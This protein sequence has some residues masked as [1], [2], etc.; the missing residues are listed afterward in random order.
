MS[1]TKTP[2]KTPDGKDAPKHAPRPEKTVN[3]P[4]QTVIDGKTLTYVA[5]AGTLNLRDP[6]DADTAS[7]FYVAYTLADVDDA[8]ARPVTFCFNGGP[9]SSSV[10]L[11]FGALGPRRVD[12]EDGATAVAPPYRLVDNAEGILDRTDLV[13][14]DPV[15][16][17][18][19]RPQGEKEHAQFQTIDEDADSIVAFVE[20]YLSRHHRWNAPRFLAGESYG[21]TRAA[22]IAWKLHQR[23]V[24]LNGLVLVSL[25]LD[26]QTFVFEPNNDLAHILY[27]PAYAA[28]ARYHGMAGADAPDLDAWMD[29]ARA[30]AY[31][32]YAPALLRG[33]ALPAERRAAVAEGLARFTGLDAGEIARRDLRI[34]Y[35]WFCKSLLGPG[36]QTIGRLDARY[37]GPD[38]DFGHRMARDPSFDAPY[39]AYAAAANDHLRRALKWEGDDAYVVFSM[40]V[41]EGWKWTQ[42]DNLGYPD[43]ATQLAKCLLAAPHLKVIVANG[44]YDLATPFSAAEYTVDHL[45]VP[46][47]LRSNVQ[48]TYYP[49]G[50]MMY[51]HP[52]SR[53]QLRAD[54]AAFYDGAVKTKG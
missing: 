37:V 34:E 6:K 38:D 41:N 29:E 24:A 1:E 23:G 42:K 46:A 28:V 51:F 32:V 9:G 31:D 45:D 21:T 18:F 30:F 35:L 39:G 26:F 40:E 44:L 43:T 25:A 20:R 27:L 22:A 54:L 48:L 7:I 2:E 33:R 12:L 3:T 16:T 13:F 36:R 17:G 50:H 14:I 52:P 47:E 10:W 53:A 49:A 4:H 15:G 19:S 5:T 8:S 11:Q